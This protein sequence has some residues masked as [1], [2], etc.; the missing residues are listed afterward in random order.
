MAGRSRRRRGQALIFLIMAVVV[1][2][3]VALWAFDVHKILYVKSL[4]QTAADAS[5]LMAARWQGITLNLIGD[6]N[7]M[8]ATAL[9]QG[10]AATSDAITNIQARLCFVGPMIAFM[11]AQQA[12][13]NNRIHNNEIYGSGIERM[14]EDAEGYGDDSHGQARFDPPYDGCW[15]EYAKMLHL[16]AAEGVAVW[17]MSIQRYD[18][19]TGDHILLNA[20]FYDAI[21]GR[22]W[23]WFFF[24]APTLLEDYHWWPDLPDPPPREYVNSE[25]L[26]LGVTKRVA[27]L[28]SLVDSNTLATVA[29]SRRG[30]S[31]PPAGRTWT[32][33]AVWYGYAGSAWSTWD[34]IAT[35]GPDAFPLTGTVKPQFDYSGADAP[36]CVEPHADLVTPGP[37]GATLGKDVI[38]SAAAKPFG[39]LPGDLRPNDCDLVLPVFTDVRLIPVDASSIGSGS[40]GG[41]EWYEHC[42]Y[43]LREYLQR[44]PMA[45]GCWYCAQLVT[46]ENPEFRH[47]GVVWLSTNSWQCTLPSGGPG[48]RRGGGTRRGH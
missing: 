35:T 31:A 23:C 18:D 17:P 26:G 14:A 33:P 36:M 8:Q 5:A 24:H 30:L 20:G 34:A 3:F 42:R 38:S 41:V 2:V 46:W 29:Q 7:I 6:L 1:L 10:D 44:G 28:A 21:A 27:E 48:N 39:S 9:S 43:H 47:E 4:S 37:R 40:G 15:E 19:P 11:A 25:V 16:I 12:A 13:K 32:T 45:N 22:L